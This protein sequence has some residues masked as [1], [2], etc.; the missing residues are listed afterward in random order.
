MYDICNMVFYVPHPSIISIIYYIYFTHFINTVIYLSYSL[1]MMYDISKDRYSHFITYM[2]I[3]IFTHMYNL[4]SICNNALRDYY[5]YEPPVIYLV[6]YS[7]NANHLNTLCL[8]CSVYLSKYI[9][10]DGY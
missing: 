7:I 5:M 2:L 4:Y 3:I 6:A 8:V 1:S 10:S 9:H